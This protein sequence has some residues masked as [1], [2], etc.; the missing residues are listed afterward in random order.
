VTAGWRSALPITVAVI[1]ATAA[2]ATVRA[3]AP[4]VAVTTIPE[5]ATVRTGTTFRV[6]VRL[7]VP[8]GRH[9]GWINPGGGGLP[10]TIGWQLPAGVRADGTEW[11]YP[12][13][14]NSSSS[15]V[16]RGTVILFS[17]FSTSA[18][19]TG[20]LRLSADLTWGLCS[21][22]C[23]RQQRAVIV[24]ISVAHGAS[25]RTQAWHEVELA[26][27]ALP[28]RVR[29]GSARAVSSADSVRLELSGLP[30]GPAVG[31]WL[32]FFPFEPGKGSVVARVRAGADGVTIALP[33]AILSG[34]PLARLS[35][36]LVAA[37]LP[38]VAPATR[39]LL[40]DVPAAP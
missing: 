4:E 28:V 17:S 6:A 39:P 27:R 9:I 18:D 19:L 12:E 11:P 25:H 1:S 2:A 20:P 29:S 23:V 30:A 31:S 21:S 7:R 8:E 5:Y 37:H 14:D 15:N 32:T 38:G 22:E 40:V 3:Q 26:Q 24:S 35:G 36:V 33:R 34:D 10:T 13:A 16:Y